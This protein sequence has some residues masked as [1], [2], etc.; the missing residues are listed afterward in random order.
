MTIN[1]LVNGGF[2]KMGQMTVQAIKAHPQLE[3]V[4]VTTK[5]YDL[6]KAIKDSK[7][8]VVV[9]FT[10]PSSVFENTNII[11]KSG[12]HPVIGTTGLT[13]EQ[14]ETF[15]KQC[16]TLQLGGVIAPNFSLG[17]VL[18]MKYAQAIAKYL[19]EVEIIESHHPQ[20]ADSPSGTA[21]YAAEMLTKTRASKLKQ[22]SPL[23]ETIPG[24]RGANFDGI[25]I[26]A[27]R[28]PGLLAH[29]E[30]MFGNRGET[31]TL[32]HDSIDRACFMPGVCLACEKVVHLKEMIYGLEHIL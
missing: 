19:P 4:G 3:L 14:I 22:K 18:L 31:L 24:A 6:A 11:I 32:K 25:P 9:D 27:V 28:L 8:Q 10:H 29:L 16:Q 23:H 30:I 7:A 15:Q 13:R 26:H 17:A 1:V 20:K 21:L 2:G 12:A 5:G